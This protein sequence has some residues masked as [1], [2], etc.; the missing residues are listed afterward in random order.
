MPERASVNQRLQLG[1]EATSGTAVAANRRIDSFDVQFGVE[2]EIN[3]YRPVGRKYSTE[4]ELNREW[5][6]GS[7]DGNMDYNGVVYPLSG[8]YGAAT[9]G[10]SNSSA[11]AKDW[12]WDAVLTGN[13]S[14]KTYTFE[15][16]DSVRAHKFAYGL[17]TK[18]GYKFDRKD[19][20]HSGE[21]LCQKIADNITM[22]STP[23]VI[24]QVP[25]PASNYSVYL[26]N[27]SAGL[28]TTKFTRFISGEFA[29][30]DVYGA[31]W[32]VDRDEASYTTHVDLA[33][34]TT[35]K[36]MLEADAAGM[37]LMNTMREGSTWFLRVEAI[38][39]QIAS[40]GGSGSD[41]VFNGFVH[42]MAV[43][44]GKPDKFSDSDGIFAIGYE[45]TIVE[46]T[47]WGHAHMLTVTNLLTTL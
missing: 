42:D 3:N 18:W 44:V 2:T 24:P 29:F 21:L 19:A 15:Q 6:S 47:T 9:I 45:L 1:I 37:A 25:M 31:A 16:G 23:T 32:F 8:V 10:A 17:F 46:D 7:L 43:K 40:D 33:P 35:F 11:T 28:G 13:A 36:L 30:E 34:K 26:D 27:A 41:P 20:T 22:T 4:Q 14:P 5:G 12:A 38:G 39:A